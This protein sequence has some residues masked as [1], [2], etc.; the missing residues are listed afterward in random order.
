[1]QAVARGDGGFVLR[2]RSYERLLKRR[3]AHVIELALLCQFPAG[4]A[5]IPMVGKLIEG[6]FA[7]RDGFA[8]PQCELAPTVEF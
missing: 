1:M 6:P 2:V 5:H 3:S 8:A 4:R 7:R